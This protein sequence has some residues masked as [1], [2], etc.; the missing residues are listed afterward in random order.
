MLELCG[1]QSSERIH[2]LTVPE[3]AAEIRVDNEKACE[4]AAVF[5]EF[6]DVK[7]ELFS[8]SEPSSENNLPNLIDMPLTFLEQKNDIRKLPI[9]PDVKNRFLLSDFLLELNFVSLR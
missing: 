8:L 5:Q 3:E 4:R 9:L 6:I 7:A 1:R 2:V